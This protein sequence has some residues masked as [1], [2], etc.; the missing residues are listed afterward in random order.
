MNA[1]TYTSS[2]SNPGPSRPITAKGRATRKR[3]I[4][5]AQDE[6]R[7]HGTLEIADVAAAAGVA[8]SVIHR[9]FGNKAGL[10]ETVVAE[11]YDDYDNAVFLAPL[12]PEAT[13]MVRET[14]RIELEVAFLYEHPL[15]RQVA[16]GLLQEAAATRVDAERQRRHA[17]M[18]ARNIRHGQHA[19]E[20]P[21]DINPDL[22]GAA[23]IGALRAVLAAALS[24]DEPPSR[25]EVVNTVTR[26]SQALLHPP[27]HPSI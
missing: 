11:F 10:V 7:R 17:A 22:A 26:L 14:L 9:Y 12:A 4:A 23:I 16:A 5:A 6:L 18:A 15:G 3:L 24:L 20:L 13:W 19:G 21:A 25:S 1:G 8:Q 27:G 2:S